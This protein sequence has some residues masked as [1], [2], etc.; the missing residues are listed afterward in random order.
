M[1][2]EALKGKTYVFEGETVT[3]VNDPKIFLRY[4]IERTGEILTDTTTFFLKHAEECN[5]EQS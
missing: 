3:V 4:R 5:Q 2:S 1:I